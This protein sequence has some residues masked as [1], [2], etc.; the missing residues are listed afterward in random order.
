MV[1]DSGATRSPLRTFEW[2]VFSDAVPVLMWLAESDG[3]RTFFNQRW[4]DFRGR[5]LADELGDGWTSGVHDD[6]RAGCLAAYQNGLR[7]GTPFE[8]AYR[9]RWA[10]GAFRH[11]VD[12]IAPRFDDEGRTI[13]FIGCCVDVTAR[14]NALADLQ[15]SETRFRLLAENASDL[16]YRYGIAPLRCEYISPAATVITGYGPHEF[17]ADLDLPWKALHPDDRWLLSE[18][19]QRPDRLTQPFLARWC[20]PDGRIVSVEHRNTPVYDDSGRLVAIEGI[21]RDVTGSLAAEAKLRESEGQLRRLAGRLEDAREKERTFI[22]RELHDEFGQLLTA[23][24]ME[25]A[26]TSRSL[27]TQGLTP[28]AIDGLQS[29]VGIVDV[30]TETVRRLATDLRPPAL[31][32]LG[33]VAA[34]ELEAAAL[35]RRTGLRCRVVGNRVVEGL[36]A[37]QATAAFRI[38]QEALTNVVRHASASVISIGISGSSQAVSITVE[39]NGRGVSD[40]QLVDPMALGL[41]GMLERAQLIGATLTVS[42]KPGK[43][44]A[45]SLTIPAPPDRNPA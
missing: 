11:V 6:D 10:D 28:G 2:V 41:R 23:I 32:H 19:R 22:A 17:Y 8:I 29:I 24:K 26:R 45:V 20:H 13:G 14:V 21:G 7:A 35:A 39:D 1:N 16:I 15:V 27:T 43:G 4:L 5:T 37:D 42:G 31:D 9:I 3:W 18:G 12:R 44:T 34:I 36:P 25:L 30:A 38:V 33:L 40:A